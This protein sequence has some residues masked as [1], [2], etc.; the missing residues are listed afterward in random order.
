MFYSKYLMVQYNPVAHWNK[1]INADY[2][3]YSNNP[4]RSRRIGCVAN[5]AN[6]LF[7]R[8]CENVAQPSTIAASTRTATLA[9]TSP[10]TSPPL[11][12]Q[13][14]S[15]CSIVKILAS[16][17]QNFAH[18]VN[19]YGSEYKYRRWSPTFR[20]LKLPSSSMVSYFGNQGLICI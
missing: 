12:S 3:R 19:I 8:S 4:R 2:N 7:Q 14:P 13:Q 6:S 9:E 18:F 11:L 10:A 17:R 5:V 20:T 16:V 15:F 1:C